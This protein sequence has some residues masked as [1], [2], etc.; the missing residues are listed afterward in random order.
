VENKE[1]Q[2]LQIR[3]ETPMK[4]QVM[5]FKSRKIYVKVVK[6]ESPKSD[7]FECL[8]LPEN[9]ETITIDRKELSGWITIKVIGSKKDIKD[10]I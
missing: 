5:Y 10:S 3:N 9:I 7:T 2:D 4:E 6:P 1:M 8:V